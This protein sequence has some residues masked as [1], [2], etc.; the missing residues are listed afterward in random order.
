MNSDFGFNDDQTLYQIQ[1]LKSTEITYPHCNNCYRKAYF[2]NSKKRW[3]KINLNFI[4]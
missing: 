4:N 3:E 1:D 2:L